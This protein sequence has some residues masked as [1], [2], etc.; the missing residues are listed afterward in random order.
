MLLSMILAKV[1]S[2]IAPQAAGFLQQITLPLL[3]VGGVS[4]LLAAGVYCIFRFL[5]LTRNKNSS[6]SADQ[7]PAL[8]QDWQEVIQSAGF[9]YDAN[10]DIFYSMMNAWQRQYGYCRL[11]DEACAPL[12]MIIDC[13]P[14]RFD[15]GGKH[16]LVEFWKGQYG[17]TAGGELGVYATDSDDI[18]VPDLFTGT[19]YESLPDSELLQL[20]FSILKDGKRFFTRE[21][22]HWWLTGF[23]LG[24]FANPSDLTMHIQII[25]NNRAMATAFVNALK[26]AGYSSREFGVRENMVRL[27]Y[28]TP[29][30]S[31]PITRTKLTDG[32]TQLKNKYLCSRYQKFTKGYTTTDQ[33]LRALASAAPKLYRR[34]LSLGRTMPVY[35]H[36]DEM[37]NSQNK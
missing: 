10:Q 5:P 26:K 30:T 25:F 22:K 20:S 9:A 7:L 4:A 17:M 2:F 35:Q 33:K 11:Y 13:E 19:L 12:S 15:Y 37:K 36:F 24:E 3:I 29:H 18:H 31:Q 14:I 8:P 16:W 27:I 6:T 32:L 34:V 23:K 28:A 21:G 1:G